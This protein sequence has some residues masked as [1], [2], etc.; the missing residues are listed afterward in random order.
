MKHLLTVLRIL[1]GLFLLMPILSILNIVPEP[2][3]EMYT[4]EG[5]AFMSAMIQTGY[6]LPLVKLMNVVCG[7]LLLANRT[8]LA[9][10]LLAPL[11]VNIVLFHIF[12]DATPL[13]PA[14]LPAYFLLVMNVY[15][16]WTNRNKYH[17]IW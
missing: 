6:L 17:T 10:I 9:A 7:V 3:A 12:L 8:A 14:S 16:L 15:Y 2:A 4:P 1:L 11:T 5:W 13:S